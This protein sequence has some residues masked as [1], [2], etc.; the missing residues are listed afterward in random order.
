[1]YMIFN[2]G[3]SLDFGEVDIENLP[4]P[5]YMMIEYIRV[6]QRA[7]N[8]NVGCNPPGFRTDQWIA[9]H[10]ENYVVNKDDEMLIPK[11]CNAGGRVAPAAAVVAVGSLLAIA[12]VIVA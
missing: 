3:M 5:S 1:M 10:K 8:V 6:Y 4:F 11:A 9:C 12:A 7:Q 2:L